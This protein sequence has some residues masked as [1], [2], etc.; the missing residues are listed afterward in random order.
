M[1]NRFFTTIEID[2]RDN[3]FYLKD[4]CY[5]PEDFIELALHI[6]CIESIHRNRYVCSRYH[7]LTSIS[8]DKDIFKAT[9]ATKEHEKDL[10]EGF[11]AP[12]EGPVKRP[13]RFMKG[14]CSR[15]QFFHYLYFHEDGSRE[16]KNSYQLM[17][18]AQFDLNMIN[19]LID[20][21][22]SNVPLP[23]ECVICRDEQCFQGIT[24][25]RCAREEE[26]KYYCIDCFR[27]LIAMN[28]SRAPC[29]RQNM[30]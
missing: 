13:G 12:L 17:Y 27:R 3:L 5:Y 4:Q 19:N 25:D 9:D 15:T 10:L 8:I 6:E 20:A 2:S 30:F 26:Q 16:W 24:C 11:F 1:M 29:C 22:R 7:D 18:M 23:F 28:D 21:N 14:N